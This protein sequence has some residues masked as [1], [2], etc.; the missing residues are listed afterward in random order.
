MVAVWVRYV[1]VLERLTGRGDLL[2]HST[3]GLGRQRD[4]DKDR[5][6]VAVDE[7]VARGH[8]FQFL[9][10]WRCGARQTGLLL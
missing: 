7:C 3:C 5:V 6:V 4:I 10:T 2:G 8:C 9:K 1:D